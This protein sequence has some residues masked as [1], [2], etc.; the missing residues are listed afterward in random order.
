MANFS[1]VISE[2]PFAAENQIKKTGGKI[3]FDLS[4]KLLIKLWM[5]F[6]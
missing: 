1:C 3:S 2:T 5:E 6:C 4:L